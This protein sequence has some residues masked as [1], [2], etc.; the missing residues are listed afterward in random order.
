MTS[1]EKNLIE[2]LNQ[3][4]ENKYIGT[5]SI[6]D[7][8]CHDLGISRSNLYRIL[9]ENFNTSPSLYIRKIKFEKAKDL[10]KTTDMKIGEIAYYIGLDGPQNFTKYFTQQHGVNPTEYRKSLSV[11]AEPIFIEESKPTINKPIILQ[12][13]K[14]QYKLSSNF[15]FIMPGLIVFLLTAFGFFY[16]KKMY[17]SDQTANPNNTITINKFECFD[18]KKGETYCDSLNLKFIKLLSE[19]EKINLIDLSDSVSTQFYENNTNLGG[20]KYL[21]TGSISSETEKNYLNIEL[22]ESGG[23]KIIWKKNFTIPNE[24]IEPK[25]IE[26]IEII[27]NLLNDK[28]KIQLKEK[29]YI[30]PDKTMT[31]YKQFLQSGQLLID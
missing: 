8:L 15:T 28:N 23:K 25:L 12:T 30:I 4:I 21:L 2:K 6:T 9:K 11:K 31:T 29:F 22:L 13:S 10:L 24:N 19:K 18:S 3:L 14:K 16:W 1:Y 7:S 26:I 5:E 27:S 20:A 17:F